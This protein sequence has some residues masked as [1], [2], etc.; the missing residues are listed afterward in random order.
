MTF[1]D[2]T[3]DIPLIVIAS[4]ST[5][6]GATQCV[7]TCHCEPLP[8]GRTYYALASRIHLM[9]RFSKAH[10]RNNEIEFFLGITPQYFERISALGHGFLVLVLGAAD[11]VLLVPAEVFEQWVQGLDTSGSGTWP[12]AFYQNPEQKSLERWV[13]GQGREDVTILRNDYASLRRALAGAGQPKTRRSR[14]T[15]RVD[16]LMEAGFLRPGDTVHTK[17]RPDLHAT[18]VDARLVGYAGKQWQ[19]NEW[20]MHITGWSA[21]NIYHQVVLDRTGQTLDE[22]RKQLA[23]RG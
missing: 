6:R 5:V 1:R 20:G 19:Y 17:K 16:D 7:G 22:L 3:L 9:F 11:N 4:L 8:F 13:P 2:S 18:I 15:H 21:I 23:K 12:M 10:H 14:T